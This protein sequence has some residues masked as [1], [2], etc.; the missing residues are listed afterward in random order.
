M[1]DELA[2]ISILSGASL[3]P[4]SRLSRA[5]DPR[6][7]CP[8]KVLLSGIAR[9]RSLRDILNEEQRELRERA[10]EEKVSDQSAPRSIRI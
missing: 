1:V 3:A 8:C 4:L 6:G 2:V 9:S 10:R 7:R 5:G